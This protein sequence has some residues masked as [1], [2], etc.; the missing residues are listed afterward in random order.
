M[1][2]ISLRLP[3]EA[4]DAVKKYAESDQVSMNFWIEALLNAEDMRRRCAAHDRMMRG[5]PDMV[6]FTEAWAE[7]NAGN[8]IQR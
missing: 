6:A 1:K 4:Y 2:T 5:N 8:L 3:D 7:H